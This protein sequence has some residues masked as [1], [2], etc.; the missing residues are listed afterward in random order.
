M[1]KNFSLRRW[2][3]RDEWMGE[4]GKRLKRLREGRGLTQQALAV[5]AGI[6]VSAVVKMEA[7]RV[8]PRWSMVRRLAEALGVKVGAFA[9]T[10]TKAEGE[11]RKG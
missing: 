10:P 9:Y 7:G 11:R 4:F 5:S 1:A 8:D 3:E 2:V 6:S